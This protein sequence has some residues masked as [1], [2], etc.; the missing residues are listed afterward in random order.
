MLGSTN[1]AAALVEPARPGL[2]HIGAAGK[3]LSGCA[4]EHIVERVAIGMKHKFPSPSIDDSVRE[5]RYLIGIPVVDVVW[6]ELKMPAKFPGVGVD[7][8]Q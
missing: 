4:I 7:G 3:E 8:Q 5:D 1:R 6:S 2:L